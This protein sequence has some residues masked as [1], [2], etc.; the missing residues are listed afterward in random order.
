M[1][2]IAWESLKAKSAI[3]TNWA[4]IGHITELMENAAISPSV[5]A[6]ILKDVFG[7][8]KSVTRTD[9]RNYKAEDFI[10]FAPTKML[11]DFVCII[12]STYIAQC[13]HYL[14]GGG[15]QLIE[16]MFQLKYICIAK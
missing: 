7:I 13:T 12:L 16:C 2:D 4:M 10:V 15:T 1:N 5:I 6:P 11:F 8:S 3:F 14:Y 9:D